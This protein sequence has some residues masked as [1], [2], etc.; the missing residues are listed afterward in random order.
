LIN[1]LLAV[2]ALLLSVVLYGN[3]RKISNSNLPVEK[4]IGQADSGSSKETGQ[5]GAENGG[6][7]SEGL[8][9]VS[10]LPPQEYTI[11]SEKNLFHPE[12]KPQEAKKSLDEA[13]KEKPD[14]IVYGT[15]ISGN[16]RLALIEDRKNPLS[17]PG[18]GKRQRLIRE[19]DEISGYK[20]IEITENSLLIGDEDDF[21]IY[22]IED[23]SKEKHRKPRTVK[24]SSNK[25]KR[26]V[27]SRER[28][29][30]RQR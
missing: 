19:R 5:S 6:D 3:Y 27:P 1:I 13:K 12:R 16:T 11:V 18:R 30:P 4:I 29:Q 23:S 17:T 22:R 25:K 9:S 10:V 20:V 8:E 7:E 21:F 2:V 14:I 15:V 28:R 24:S 26:G